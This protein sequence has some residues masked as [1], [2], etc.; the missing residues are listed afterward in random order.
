MESYT[1]SQKQTNSMLL[2]GI[3]ALQIQMK[4]N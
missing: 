2:E 4:N 3:H 1:L